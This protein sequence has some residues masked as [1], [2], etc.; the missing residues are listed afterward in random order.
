MNTRVVRVFTGFSFETMVADGGS[1]HW[2]ASEKS[3][4]SC[5]YVI[6]VKHRHSKWSEGP[7]DHHTAFLI[8][9]IAGVKPSPDTF[10][11]KLV[12]V[13]DRFAT[14]NIPNAW[15]TRRRNPVSYTDLETLKIDVDELKWQEFP[16]AKRIHRYLVAS[17]N[18][19]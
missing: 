9:E 19:V 5:S 11:G 7:E 3:I 1:G 16:A 14:L 13:F 15:P 4:L 8:G 2:L 10:P 18:G 17:A 6:A 12:I